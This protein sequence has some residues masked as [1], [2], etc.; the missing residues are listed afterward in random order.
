[1]QKYLSPWNFSPVEAKYTFL[2][3]SGMLPFGENYKK[4]AKKN[5][6]YPL[7]KTEEDTQKHLLVCPKFNLGTVS[8][9][10]FPVYDDLFNKKNYK[11]S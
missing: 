5:P 2:C 9:T 1:M 3:R 10:N 11:N 6:H 7:C 8:A 4:G